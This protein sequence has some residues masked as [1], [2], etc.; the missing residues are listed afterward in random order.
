MDEAKSK[1]HN[2]IRVYQTAKI[3]GFAASVSY[4]YLPVDI[5][6]QLKRHLLDAVGSLIQAQT[7]TTIGKLGSQIDALKTG[8]KCKVPM[9]GTIPVDRAAQW[10]TALIRYPDFMDN[11][12]G[13]EATCHPS[14]NIGPL[15]AACQDIETDGRDFLAA[16]AI[17]Y[18]IECRLVED[19]PV[20][21]KGFDHLALYAY[22]ITAGLSNLYKLSPTQTAHALGIAGS[23]FMPLVTSRA[24]YTY[25]WKG[26]ASSLVALGCMNIVLMAKHD[27]TGPISVF[28]GPKGI[29][30]ILDM[31]LDH[32]WSADDL[33]IIRRCVLKSF[34]AEVHTQSSLEAAQDLMAGFN[35]D[36]SR[37]ESVDITTFLTAYHIVGG[38]VYGD[39][40][41]VHS[42]EQADHSLPYVLA[43]LLLDG[44]V[45]PE[46]L[47]PERINRPDVQ[48]LLKKIKVDTVSPLHKPLPFAGMLDPYTEAYPEKLKAKL[49]IKM[50]DGK[51]MTKEKDDYHGFYTRPFTWE[52]TVMKF[53]KLTGNL[54][55]EQAK[56]RIIGV[57]KDFENHPVEDLASLLEAKK[58]S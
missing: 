26:L 54:I 20:M 55:E 43:V 2:N 32:H 44:E 17:A 57:V 35:L 5:R 37:I 6:E 31:K 42:K 14:D 13:K 9:L 29:A 19:L 36:P 3:A 8:G 16:M 18:T 24:A 33:S 28:E 38:G 50:T 25:E 45:Y 15:L 4:N 34:N 49:V 39:R 27:V 12:I 21:I 40:K 53:K 7:S 30:Q 51:K 58:T 56:E 10:Y 41:N 1:N 47:L 46:Q 23:A 22:S 48:N 11:F 52:D